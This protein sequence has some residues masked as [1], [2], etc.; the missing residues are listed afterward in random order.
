MLEDV[1]STWNPK[2]LFSEIVMPAQCELIR[3]EYRGVN[4]DRE[5]RDARRREFEK[6]IKF[7]VTDETF[8]RWQELKD[9]FENIIGYENDSKVFE[10]AIIEALNIPLESIQ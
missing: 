10:F 5:M 2:R 1:N 4:I 8:A 3:M 6:E 9:R 7:K